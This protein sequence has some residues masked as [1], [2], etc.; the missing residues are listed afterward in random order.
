M[1]GA[2]EDRGENRFGPL[3]LLIACIP[4]PRP[5]QILICP[6]HQVAGAPRHGVL[7][8]YLAL[9]ISAEMEARPNLENEKGRCNK[10]AGGQMR[11]PI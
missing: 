8:A 1:A 3:F 2:N 10:A 11:S 6:R 4:A 5:K 7:P 9:G